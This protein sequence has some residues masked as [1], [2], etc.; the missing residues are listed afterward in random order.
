[1]TESGFTIARAGEDG[2][3]AVLRLAAPKANAMSPAMLAAL[4]AAVLEVIAGDASSLVITGSGRSFS[5]GLALT[6]IVDYDRGQLRDFMNG[7]TDVMLTVLTCPKPVVAAINGH[8]IA[9][10]CVLALMCD[11]R[12]MTDAKALIGLKEV[13]LGIG[14]PS[15]VI[16]PLRARVPARSL[17]PIALAAELFTPEEALGLE[18]IDDICPADDLEAS[19]I[20]RAESLTG[21]PIAYA[22]VKAAL[23][24]PTLDAI[25]AR[26]DA[27]METWLDSWFSPDGQRLVRATVATLNA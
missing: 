20:T 7:F 27:V 25:S 13:A 1:M 24:D 16:E 5:A 26:N 3:V 10:G 17:A 9:G 22:Q 14:L 6:E 19:A 18:L 4:K 23:L 12:L 2:S 8:A 15:G 21:P 11:Y